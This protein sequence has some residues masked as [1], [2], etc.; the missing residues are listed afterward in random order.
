M[1]GKGEPLVNPYSLL[2]TRIKA[3]N[4][5]PPSV[6]TPRMSCWWKIPLSLGNAISSMN[7][8]FFY[9]PAFPSVLRGKEKGSLKYP[10][11]FRF[12][13]EAKN[14]AKAL[15]DHDNRDIG[16]DRNLR[17]NQSFGVLQRRNLAQLESGL[18]HTINRSNNRYSL[19]RGIIRF[20]IQRHDKPRLEF[21]SSTG[22][23]REVTFKG[24]DKTFAKKIFELDISTGNDGNTDAINPRLGFQFDLSEIAPQLYPKGQKWHSAFF[25]EFSGTPNLEFQEI[26]FNGDS[27]NERALA[28]A[29]IQSGLQRQS[30]L[31]SHT[32]RRFIVLFAF[33]NG[34]LFF[35]AEDYVVDFPL[36]PLSIKIQLSGH[37]SNM[38]TTNFNIDK[39]FYLNIE[40][41]NKMTIVEEAA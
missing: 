12:C 10:S 31:M 21:A 25:L 2:K 7:K 37:A 17:D 27:N 36:V 13:H 35:P 4:A 22:T 26:P 38:P 15:P 39:N 34:K 6:P 24:N 16:R 40:S 3:A 32:S 19:H 33:E 30:T 41:W 18:K 8:L 23:I 1:E 5:I 11:V 9:L 29:L 14:V 20:F 28:Y